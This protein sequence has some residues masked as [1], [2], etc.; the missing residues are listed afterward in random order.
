[1]REGSRRVVTRSVDQRTANQRAQWV[2]P[3]RAAP[4]VVVLSLGLVGLACATGRPEPVARSAPSVAPRL[5]VPQV[6]AASAGGRRAASAV[7]RVICKTTHGFGT[8]FLHRSGLIITA[9]HVV[10]GCDRKD[11]EIRGAGRRSRVAEIQMDLRAD[12]AL[13]RPEPKLSGTPLP[14]SARERFPVGLQVTTW[15]FPQGYRG[16]RPLLS[17]GYLAG[18]ELEPTALGRV[19]RWVVNAAFNSGNS[20]GPLLDL[21]DEAVMGVVCSKLAPVPP[22]VEAALKALERERRGVVFRARRSDGTIIELSEGEVVATVLDYLRRQTQ[23]VIGY[24][25]T[26]AQIRRFLEANGVQP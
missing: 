2:P 10:S 19:Q 1:M 13:L 9:A 21:E 8:G 15:G 11:L 16:A 18:T 14:I 12:L 24:A 17:V 20:G 26:S 23:L 25:A 4:L 6:P 3:I 5:A 22:R 7:F